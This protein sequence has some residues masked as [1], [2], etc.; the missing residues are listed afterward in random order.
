MTQ[1]IGL[2]PNATHLHRPPRDCQELF[3]EGERHS[4]LFQIQPLGSPPF[5][6]N[7]EMTSDGGWTVIQRRLNGSVDFNQ[8]WEAYKD[9]FGD[10]Q[11]EFWLGLEKMHSI[12]GNRGSQLA[13]QLQ[14]WDGNAK[15]LQFPIHLGVRTQPTACSSLSPRPMSWVPPM[16]PPMAFPC[17]SLL[18]TKTM[19]SV[20]TLTVPR[21]SLVA[22]GLVPVAIPISM[23]NTSTLSHGNGRS[24]KRVS[25]GKH[26]R[27]ATILCRLPPC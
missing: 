3:Q 1:L 16:F 2:T 21:A 23:D 17:P 27:A 10:P 6:V 26:G 5:L 11:G 22:G 12:T 19:T 8:S 18:G 24:V 14:D 15:L 25:S 9:G 13:V 7:C 4:G 20:G